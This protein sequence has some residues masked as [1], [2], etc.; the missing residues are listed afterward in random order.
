MDTHQLSMSELQ[1]LLN[2]VSEH[3]S[4]H[5][6]E[7]EADLDQT[8][9]LLAQAIKTLSSGFMQISQLVDQQQSE[10]PG[11]MSAIGEKINSEINAVVTGLQFQDLTNQL[12]T[13]SVK[14]ISGVRDLLTVLASHQ[15]ETHLSQNASVEQLLEKMHDSLSVKSGALKEGLSQE[16]KQKHM[17]SGEI[18][19][20]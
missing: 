16:V 7:A 3:G 8:L 9:F 2:C 14:R 4:Q 5:L 13:R 1:R 17:V 10:S 18:E 11:E 6:E 20:F 12:I 19:L 15:I